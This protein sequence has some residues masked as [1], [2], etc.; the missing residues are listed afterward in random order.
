MKNPENMIRDVTP[1]RRENDKR[2]ERFTHTE[3]RVVFFTMLLDKKI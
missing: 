3:K 2:R 1:H